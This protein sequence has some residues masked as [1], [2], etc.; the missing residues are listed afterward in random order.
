MLYTGSTGFPMGDAYTNRVLSIAKGL[1]SIGCEVK[2]LIVYP[3]RSSGVVYK[4]G[5]YDTVPYEY[6]TA[7]ITSKRIIIKKI[8]GVSGI[9]KACY[10][11]LT[12]HT[13]TDAIISFTAST[14]QNNTISFVA[15][16]KRIIFIRETSEYPGIVLKKG[17]NGLTISEKKE[18]KNSLKQL[19][20][21]I[22]I[23]NSL[24]NYFK[25]NHLFNK[26][27]LI[28]PIVVDKNRFAIQPFKTK[29]KF[30]TYCGNLFGEKDGV[31][32]LV[33]AFAKISQKHPDYKLKLIGE[34]SN[35]IDI[36]RLEQLINSLNI[37]GEVVFTGYIGR[38]EIPF[39]L[40]NS[41]I[42]ALARPDNIQARGGFPTKLGEY[43]ATGKPVVVTAVGDIP[44][45]LTDGV[46]VFLALPGSVESFAEKLD[47]VI[48]NYTL[49]EKTGQEGRMLVDTIFSPDYQA[50]R[51]VKFIREIAGTNS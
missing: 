46:N 45:Y 16:L 44:D 29:E 30:I 10:Q 9:L 37:S 1:A 24:K 48:E 13:G 27:I 28:V 35:I 21:L 47:Y 32:I 36:D 40:V 2:L 31:D 38:E 14:L 41:D 51:I 22:C 4:K 8:I 11:I 42:L 3:G 5:V 50:S 15:H 49:A 43:L 6:L 25:I 17:I 26:P 20:G 18:I 12:R 39:H 33:R 34:T 7:V 23:S 19:D